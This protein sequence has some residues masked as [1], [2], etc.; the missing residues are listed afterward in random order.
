MA[1]SLEISQP[2]VTKI[3]LKIVFLRFYWNIPEANQLMPS[4]DTNYAICGCMYGARFLRTILSLFLVVCSSYSCRAAV[5]WKEQ[6][7][8]VADII[9]PKCISDLVIQEYWHT[10]QGPVCRVSSWGRSIC[11]TGSNV[12]PLKSLFS[13]QP[14]LPVGYSNATHISVGY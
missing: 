1:I 12:P 6:W 8:V 9:S 7:A 3:S 10:F 13:Y 11:R 2:S 14:H 5:F 4:S